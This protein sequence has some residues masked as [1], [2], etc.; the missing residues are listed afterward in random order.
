VSLWGLSLLKTI[1][2]DGTYG[3]PGTAGGVF[4]SSPAALL[5]TSIAR[6]RAFWVTGAAPAGSATVINGFSASTPR[7]NFNGSIQTWNYDTGTAVST[8]SW[9]EGIH[10]LVRIDGVTAQTTALWNYLAGL[11]SSATFETS[12]SASDKVIQAAATG[13]FDSTIA[14]PTQFETTTTKNATS[15]YDYASAGLMAGVAST[16]SPSSLASAKES[17]AVP[18]HRT[19]EGSRRDSR[20][21]FLGRM[22]RSGLTFQPY[23][24]TNV[25]QESVL[26]AAQTGFLYRYRQAMGG[27]E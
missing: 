10:S 9:A 8:G 3:A 1:A 12:A 11:E 26:F 22:G 14:P 4:T 21:Q 2:G 7:S 17:I 18:R 15:F 25:R 27:D 19:A 23:S 13:T 16:A 6:H 20:T 24:G 5:S